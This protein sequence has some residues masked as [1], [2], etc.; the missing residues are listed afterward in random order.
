MLL[1]YQSK[2]NLDMI[3]F[4]QIYWSKN[5]SKFEKKTYIFDLIF[6]I[7]WSALSLDSNAPVIVAIES[8]EAASP[9]KNNLSST[10]SNK[11]LLH[12]NES[13]LLKEYP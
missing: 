9:A 4:A 13:N 5:S 7:W 6:I 12:P 11:S 10:F 8:I 1:M 3:N 2:R